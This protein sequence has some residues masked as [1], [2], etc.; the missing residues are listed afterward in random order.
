M[1]DPN[2]RIAG[3]LPKSF[4]KFPHNLC[5][6]PEDIPTE[7]HFALIVQESIV[8]SDTYDGETSNTTIYYNLYYAF[9]SLEECKQVYE[10]KRLKPNVYS[11]CKEPAIISVKGRAEVKV[12]HVLKFS[13][14]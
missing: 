7:P 12:E 10:T 4:N 9:S 1:F 3:D 6:D 14:V 13:E 11:S 8:S 5:K 2:K